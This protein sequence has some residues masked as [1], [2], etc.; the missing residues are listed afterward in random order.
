M[1]SWDPQ[2]QRKGSHD[3]GQG[4]L[5]VLELHLHMDLILWVE[6]L[7]H[8]HAQPW[9]TGFQVVYMSLSQVLKA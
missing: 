7:P 3:C 4:M 5:A 9:A 6:L 8:T 1:L 2:L